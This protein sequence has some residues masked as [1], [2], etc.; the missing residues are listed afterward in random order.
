MTIKRK[1]AT[2]YTFDTDSVRDKFSFRY[3][4]LADTLPETDDKQV[5]LAWMDEYF[6]GSQDFEDF[7]KFIDC[8]EED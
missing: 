2:V 3:P 7:A 5:W 1:I 6:E 4:E 8:Y